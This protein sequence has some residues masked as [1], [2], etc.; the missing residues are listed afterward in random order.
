MRVMS[1][2]R[3]S[4]RIDSSMPSA[5]IQSNASNGMSPDSTADVCVAVYTKAASG[6]TAAM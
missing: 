1:H 2:E 6:S 3:L 5:G 4:S